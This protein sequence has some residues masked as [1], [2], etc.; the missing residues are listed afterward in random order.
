MNVLVTNVELEKLLD[1]LSFW[2]ILIILSILALSIL[3]LW[4]GKKNKSCFEIA[5]NTPALGL[6]AI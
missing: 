1:Q 4:E 3:V 5:Q 2:F 6:T